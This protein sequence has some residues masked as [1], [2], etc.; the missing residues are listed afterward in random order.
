MIRTLLTIPVVGLLVLAGV[1]FNAPSAQAECELPP[2]VTPLAY[3]SV[4]AQQVA[5]AA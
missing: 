5:T 2:G 1:F 3:P 4:T